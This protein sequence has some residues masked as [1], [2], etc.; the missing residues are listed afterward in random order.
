MRRWQPS[1]KRLSG[2]A[3]LIVVLL[4]AGFFL[5][6]QGLD[7][8]DK[9]ASIGALLIGIVSL[10]QPGR[11]MPASGPP[12]GA[13]V[14]AP[15]PLLDSLAEQNLRR[16][17]EIE[18]RRRRL[19]DPVP[20]PVSWMNADE[21]ADHWQNICGS[22]EPSEP[23]VLDGRWEDLAATFERVPSRR[24]AVV[25]AGG[26]G[27]S[28]LCLHLA[29]QLLERRTPGDPVP[30]L[31]S[32][33]SWNPEVSSLEDW[34]CDRLPVDVSPALSQD[35]GDGRTIARVMVEDGLMIPILDG[36]DELPDALHHRAVERINDAGRGPLF[37]TCREEEFAHATS[38]D[39]LTATAVARLRPLPLATVSSWLHRT[40]PAADR[41]TTKWTPVLSAVDSD[42]APIA[43]A[44]GPAEAG[45]HEPLRMVLSSPL[46]VSLARTVYSETSA[47]PS[48]LLAARMDAR[49]M[50]EQHLLRQ[51]IP[52]AYR[53]ATSRRQRA[54]TPEQVERYLVNLGRYLAT[55]DTDRWEWWRLAHIL[56]RLRVRLLKA[57][58]V[59][60]VGI[61]AFAVVQLLVVGR[62]ALDGSMIVLGV[63]PALAVLMAEPGSPDRA[64]VAQRLGFPAHMRPALAAVGRP[65][66][67]GLVLG[68]IV[69]LVVAAVIVVLIWQGP[70]ILNAAVFTE[71]VLFVSRIIAVFGFI[72]L[73]LGA[74]VSVPLALLKVFSQPLPIDRIPSPGVLLRTDRAW[75]LVQAVVFGA[76]VGLTFLPALLYVLVGSMHLLRLSGLQLQPAP[77]VGTIIEPVPLFA[78]GVSTALA[79]VLTSTAWGRF[80]FARTYLAVTRRAPWRLMAF[81]AEA[82]DRGVLRQVGPA[83][84]F[85]HERLQSHLTAVTG[86]SSR[87]PES[88]DRSLPEAAAQPTPSSVS[89]AR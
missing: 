26:Q 1:R 20:L 36:L 38:R 65:A 77:E 11:R 14:E 53:D 79:F 45:A 78:L 31:L 18:W 44:Q 66:L 17:W 2:G 24:L 15:G 47:D 50:I 28:V 58:V 63:V 42:A 62:V 48:E 43:P 60:V 81:L 22:A 19:H 56:P 84:T 67:R 23:L 74:V 69:G 83:Y 64:P 73:G 32:L 10:C 21:L 87:P 70:L 6:T 51:L 8:A 80:T 39:V 33:S 27:K 34:L 12:A 85:R 46:M 40:A 68:S 72:G 35:A 13:F 9:W 82:R 54:W 49:D 88:I 89:R 3:L 59:A 52:A 7:E 30:V 29:R 41:S 71:V 86:S 57:A 37:L 75:S 25:G 5:K 55:K 16:S 4:G 61:A 76:V